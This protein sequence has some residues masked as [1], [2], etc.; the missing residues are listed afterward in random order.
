MRVAALWFPDWP[1]QAARLD[2]DQLAAPLAVGRRHRVIAYDDAARASGVRRGM[3][4]R[5]AQAVCP[6]LSVLEAN[7]DRDGAVFA[8]IAQ[9]LDEVASSVEVMRPGLVIV[10][11]AAA[12]RFHGGED[13]A[14]EMLLDAAAR[15]GVDMTVGVADEIATAVIAARHQRLGAVVPPGCSR[16]FLA[17]QPI[18]VLA[19]EVALE[20]PPEL[21]AK[22]QQLGVRTLEQL[23]Q[24]P[25]SQVTT[26]FGEPV[27]RAHALASAQPDRRVAPEAEL[28]DLAVALSPEEP[29]ERVDAAAFAARQLAASLHRRL[30]DAGLACQRLRVSAE[31]ST[32]ERLERVWRTRTA[33][34]EDATADRVRWQL[35]G[36]L[37]AARARQ[38]GSGH[39]DQGNHGD[40]VQTA[41]EGGIVELV[42]DPLE[43]SAPEMVGELWGSGASDEQARRVI[44]RVQSQLGV[45]RVLV[46]RAVGG[47]GVAE[48]IELVP[49]GERRDPLS[50]GTW[51]GRIPAPLPA[52]LG[53]GPNHP[54]ARIRLIDAAGRDVYVT[55]EA[56]LST[57]PYALG[58]GRSRYRVAGW[59]GPWPVDAP[60]WREADAA[61][62]ARL[63]LV[64]QA[65][66]EQFQRAW[67]LVWSAGSWRVEATYA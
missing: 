9:G 22:L 18:G 48:R 42:L 47:R 49:Y 67:L 12:G 43:T 55:A 61:P 20:C 11:A 31:L 46:P 50:E 45:D 35:D 63:Q 6:A 59:A 29:I 54:A 14:V 38:R 19:A 7:P 16:R 13:K 56:L 66:N 33:L 40:P 51:P 58:W 1:L 64:G 34:T 65:D 57:V 30:A 39:G 25:L 23:A 26:R 4:V 5:Q 36:W 27:R 2:D 10:D 28:S 8:E 3:R 52:R 21:V 37:T 44:S 17:P 62:C 41:T 24:L 32:G 53:G 60:W 15:R